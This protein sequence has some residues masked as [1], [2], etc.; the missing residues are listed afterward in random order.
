MF[1]EIIFYFFIEFHF[2]YVLFFYY[3]KFSSS[4]SLFICV[5]V[6]QW[7]DDGKKLQ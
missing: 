5:S 6:T 2:Y 1:F 7:I 3:T 4:F